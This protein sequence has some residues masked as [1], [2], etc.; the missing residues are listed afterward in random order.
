[1]QD[2]E[3][4]LVVMEG[5]ILACVNDVSFL[6]LCVCLFGQRMQSKATAGERLSLGL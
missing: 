3:E 4:R 1:M 2:E 6:Q 5:K